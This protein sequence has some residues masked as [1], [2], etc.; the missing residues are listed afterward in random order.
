MARTA[1]PYYAFMYKITRKH[2]HTHT[3]PVLVR[4]HYTERVTRFEGRDGAN[5]GGNQ[6]GGGNR[7][8]NGGGDEDGARAGRGV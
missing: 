6:A 8:R 2:T 5:G 4:A 3:R 7:D 1:G